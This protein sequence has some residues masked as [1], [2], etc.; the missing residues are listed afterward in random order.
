MA[1][2]TPKAL[3][4]SLPSGKDSEISDRTRGEQRT[5]DTL[6]GSGREQNP[7]RGCEAA[8]GRRHHEADETDD[9]DPFAA[10]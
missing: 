6:Q 3:A 9:E 4:R 7:G 1:A 10:Q 2:Y 8:Q 5:E